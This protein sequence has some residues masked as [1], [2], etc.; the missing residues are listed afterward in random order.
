[1]SY[2]DLTSTDPYFDDFDSSKNYHRILFKPG[3]AVQAREL[4]QAQ[5]ILQN[6]VTNFAD[7][8]FKQNSPVTG[9]Q[10]TT[11]FN[12]YYIKLQTTYLNKTIDVTQFNGLLLTDA[13][14]TVSARVIAVATPTGGDAPT[15]VVTYLSG[16]QFTDNAVIYDT[17]S[18]LAAQAIASGSTGTSSVASI[19]Q[20]VFYVLGTFVQV[21][22]ST[23]ILSKYSSSPSIRVGLTISEQVVNYISD[24]SLLDPA[25]GASNYQA[26]GADRYQ[27]NLTLDTRPLALGDD[28]NFIELVR[29]TAGSVAKLVDGSVYNVID[30]YFAKRDYETNGDYVVNDFKL[31]PKSANTSAQY[32]MSI[33]KGVAYVRGYRLENSAPINLISD[34]ARTTASQNNNPVYI[35]IG[36]FFYVNSVNGANATFFDTTTTQP[37]DIHCVPVANVNVT[38]AATYTPTV[39]GSGYIRALVY[40]HNTVDTNANTYVYKAYVHDIQLAAP[41]AN[42]IAA[43]ANTITLPSTY[44]SQNTAYVGVN[45]SI[46]AGT[47]VGD[48]RTITSYNGVTKVATVNQNWTTVPDTTS[49]F[50]LNFTIGN[51]NT[52]VSAVTSSYPATIDAYATIEIGRAHV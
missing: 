31:T 19:A 24:A 22:P 30:D 20:G 47:D 45:I 51:A 18:N 44:S 39:V 23:V 9:G 32:T 16:T 28:S 42:A 36:S 10:V 50:A 6:Q 38:S 1:M 35:G 21:N 33:G 26:P 52:I 13:T 29:V 4:T 34:R 41:S 48:T 14:G 40:D 17:A 8:I 43:T 25:V 3:Y 7:N 5:T 11:N 12:C 49:V 15:L 27:I 37:I 46:N 2:S